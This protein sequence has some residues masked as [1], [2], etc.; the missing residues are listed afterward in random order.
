VK[1]RYDLASEK[2]LE[3]AVAELVPVF[4]T[5]VTNRDKEALLYG[6]MAGVLG[7]EE[8]V[9]RQMARRLKQAAYYDGTNAKGEEL[10]PARV[11]EKKAKPEKKGALEGA[12][13]Y[14]LAG[15]LSLPLAELS[16]EELGFMEQSAALEVLRETE[17][18]KREEELKKLLPGAMDSQ[19]ELYQAWLQLMG[20]GGGLSVKKWAKGLSS[21]ALAEMDRLESM[22]GEPSLT[23]G[24]TIG[25]VVVNGSTSLSDRLTE[26]RQVVREI[27]RLYLKKQLDTL[28][29]SL[30]LTSLDSQQ[31]LQLQQQYVAISQ[32]LAELL[33]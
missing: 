1:K 18:K 24:G 32:Q 27:N 28:S 10:R 23:D 19:S 29:R 21:E 4:L 12:V 16:V 7:V 5:N 9:L 17:A 25:V 31:V 2:G 13:D 8:K 14:L 15:L 22:V 20:V 33:K 30:K 6:K 26:L 11:A 3:K